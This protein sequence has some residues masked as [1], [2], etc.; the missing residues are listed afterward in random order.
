M[1]INDKVGRNSPV[2]RD[3]LKKHLKNP[4]SRVDLI[5][6]FCRNKTVLDLGCVNHNVENTEDE[7]WLH[8]HI[9]K[10]AS[11]LIGVDYSLESCRQLN[12]RGYEVLHGDVTKT[13]DIHDKFDVIH[14]GN[15]IEH[16]SNF[17]GLFLNIRRLL[18]DNGEV[19]ISTANPFY[20]EQYFYSAIKNDILVNPEHTCW[21][22]PVTLNELGLRYGFNTTDVYWI[23][24]K[25]F[26]NWVIL[27]GRKQSLDILTG[28]WIRYSDVTWAEKVIT[29]VSVEL[30][31]IFFNKKYQKLLTTQKDDLGWHI[32]R[33]VVGRMFQVFWMIY[34][35]LIVKAP[36]NKYELYVSVLK[37]VGALKNG[38]VEN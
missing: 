17:E 28:K 6:K 15:I 29:G 36:I 13:L 32:Y 33:R 3:F 16:L 1:A 35:L 37:K 21:I 14:V 22:D 38:P 2:D 18:K 19:L 27:N 8:G 24:E 12:L 34:S 25:W 9:R 31:R 4:V 20:S 7:N 23:K 10:V 26:I 11:H 30:V 5:T